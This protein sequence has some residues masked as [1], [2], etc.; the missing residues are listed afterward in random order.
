MSVFFFFRFH[1]SI[2]LQ[3]NRMWKH[4]MGLDTAHCL[5]VRFSDMH[6]TH[7]FLSAGAAAGAR[8]GKTFFSGIGRFSDGFC[9]M[10]DKW[11]SYL[12]EQ[13]HS[14]A[15]HQNLWG[16]PVV[17]IC[18][19]EV[20]WFFFCWRLQLF[21]CLFLVTV[22]QLADVYIFIFPYWTQLV[23]KTKEWK[24]FLLWTQLMPPPTPS[25]CSFPL[26]SLSGK[27]WFSCWVLL[28]VSVFL[29]PCQTREERERKKNSTAG[30]SVWKPNK[31]TC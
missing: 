5:Y 29:P 22:E 17:L 14:S 23:S 7:D 1:P 2:R 6:H 11:R 16:S 10:I 4:L 13:I 9:Q 28:W 8:G 24:Q 21:L 3:W 19:D 15:K 30:A 12:W 27:C 31:S 25:P 18:V 26:V 20:N